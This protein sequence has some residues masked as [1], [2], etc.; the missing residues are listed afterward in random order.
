MEVLVQTN[1]VD[2]QL[3]GV[4]RLVPERERVRGHFPHEWGAFARILFRLLLSATT[5]TPA[6]GPSPQC[7]TLLL[8]AFYFILLSSKNIPL[9][10]LWLLLFARWELYFLPSQ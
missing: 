1:D 2:T 3:H 9:Q 10:L 7:L 8:F 6:P 4:D 5:R